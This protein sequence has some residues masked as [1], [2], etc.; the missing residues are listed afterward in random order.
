MRFAKP[1]KTS[2]PLH[3]NTR[4]HIQKHLN[5]N[6]HDR[7]N[8]TSTTVRTSKCRKETGV[9]IN[10]VFPNTCS[11]EP[12]VVREIVEG[13]RKQPE[14]TQKI[15]NVPGKKT[16]G[17]LSGNWHH[18]HPFKQFATQ[19]RPPG[20]IRVFYITDGSMR[21]NKAHWYQEHVSTFVLSPTVT[22]Y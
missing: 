5:I 21:I 8:L 2:V 9:K 19:D 1:Y 14:K 16:R 17:L 20:S 7:E 10:A 18:K 6:F 3:T 22:T 4:R 13:R 15:P 12:R 11:A